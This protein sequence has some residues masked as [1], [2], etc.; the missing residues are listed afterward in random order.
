MA[1]DLDLLIGKWTV[2]VKN[3]IWEYEFQRDG[4]VTWR[5]RHSAEKGSGN[6][7]AT[8]KLVNMWWNGSATLAHPARWNSTI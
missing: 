7:A 4:R 6:W 5:D 1:G 3:W 8:S 2:R